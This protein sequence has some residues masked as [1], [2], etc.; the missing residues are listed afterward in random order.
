[1]S[2]SQLTR[3]LPA[4][5][6]SILHS[7]LVDISV[8]DLPYR[9]Q[10]FRAVYSFGDRGSNTRRRL[11]YHLRIMSETISSGG[12]GTRLAKIT[13]V[14]AGV[15]SLAATLISF[16]FEPRPR[17]H[18][19]KTPANFSITVRYGSKREQAAPKLISMLSLTVS[20]SKNYRKPLLQRY[21]V[22]ILLM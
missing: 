17:L 20:L 6:T 16:L 12:T 4:E 15:A 5:E 1:V 14:L 19:H 7:F 21:V 11:R 18:D 3:T 22:R 8:N 9:C 10:N 13:I 2:F